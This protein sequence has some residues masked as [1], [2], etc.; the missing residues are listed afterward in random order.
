MARIIAALLGTLL[1]ERHRLARTRSERFPA[2]TV[3]INLASVVAQ[4]ARLTWR[5][6]AT[7]QV[8]VRAV[9]E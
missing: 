4:A 7:T 3:T 9:V 2:T 6:Q 8:M 5:G 1:A